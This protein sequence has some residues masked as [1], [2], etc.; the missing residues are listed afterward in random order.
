MITISP[1]RRGTSWEGKNLAEMSKRSSIVLVVGDDNEM[2]E[3]LG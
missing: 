1:L 2:S 3:V